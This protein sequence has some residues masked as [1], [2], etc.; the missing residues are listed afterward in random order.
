MERAVL[1]VQS[2]AEPI[3]PIAG[4]DRSGCGF[5]DQLGTNAPVTIEKVCIDPKRQWSQI[6]NLWYNAGVRSILYMLTAPL[7]WLRRRSE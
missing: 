2:A 1:G 7:R 4:G 5:A 3:L 6:T